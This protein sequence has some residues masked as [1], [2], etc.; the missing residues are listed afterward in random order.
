MHCYIDPNALN[1]S[2]QQLGV[3]DMEQQIVKPLSVHAP[4]RQ[5]GETKE[6]YRARQQA[7]REAF[8]ASQ[9]M[10]AESHRAKRP[11]PKLRA[12]WVRLEARRANTGQSPAFKPVRVRKPAQPIRRDAA[13]SFALTG[14]DPLRRID[15]NGKEVRRIWRDGAPVH[16]LN[17]NRERDAGKRTKVKSAVAK[18]MDRPSRVATIDAGHTKLLRFFSV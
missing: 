2:A 9:A 8:I 11:S 17:P 12:L 18:R 5:V 3:R 14:R 10:P 16:N 4:E 13:G 15:T 7:S 1:N 6:Q